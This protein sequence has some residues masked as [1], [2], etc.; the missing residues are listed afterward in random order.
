MKIAIGADHG[1]FGLK[2]TIITHLE[3]KGH[4]V[5]DL[6]SYNTDSVDYPEFGE[7]VAMAVKNKE[8]DRGIVIC[9]TGLGISISANKVPGIRAALVSETFSARMSIEHN[10]A[11]ILALGARVTGPDL[12]LEIVD[13]WTEARFLGDRHERRVNKIIDIENK[14]SK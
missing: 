2:G 11:N 10:N 3:E 5:I 6:G 13:V 14:Y 7:K 12:A 4:E 9:G 1:G 8:V